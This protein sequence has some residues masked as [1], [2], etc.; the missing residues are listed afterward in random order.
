[1]TDYE[2]CY[3]ANRA[4]NNLLEGHNIAAKRIIESAKRSEI[5]LNVITLEEDDNIIKDNYH[6]IKISETKK[7]KTTFFPQLNEVIKS[8]ET[9]KKTK[10]IGCDAIHLLNVN[11]EIINLQYKF[12]NIKKPLIVHFFHSEIPFEYKLNYK[13]RLFLAKR[14][15]YK[16]ILCT[17][18]KV[19]K[20]LRSKISNKEI[21]IEKIPSPID[22][23]NYDIENKELYRKKHNISRESKIILYVGQIDF[24]RGFFDVIQSFKSIM[25]DNKDAYLYICHPN[26]KNETQ[27]YYEYLKNYFKD[28]VDKIIFS[29]PQENLEEIYILSDVILLPF[30]EPYWATAPP[31][32]IPEAMA[33]NTPLITTPLDVVPELNS[34]NGLYFV[35]PGNI[36]EISN[37]VNE[38]L[39][40]PGLGNKLAENSRKLIESEYDFVSVGKKLKKIYEEILS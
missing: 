19:K 3:I 22:L 10:D 38:L 24:D 27:Y 29:G 39:N 25:S 40:D 1:M 23:T 5:N 35:E 34:T 11:K 36:K 18:E 21:L 32:V 15:Y 28:D 6:I 26:L 20:Y 13:L 37:A 9:I 31:L 8:Y 17:N 4:I 30:R 33:S 7:R 16:N 12:N 2:I 14:G